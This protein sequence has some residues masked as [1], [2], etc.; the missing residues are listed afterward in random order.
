MKFQSRWR[1]YALRAR[2]SQRIVHKDLGGF[3]EVIPPLIAKFKGSGRIF[4]SELAQ[5]NFDWTDDER[6]FVEAKILNHKDFGGGIY[7][8]PGE[9]LTEEQKALVRNQSV[10]EEP[11]KRCVSLST[12]G[13]DV[14]QCPNE[15]EV[16]QDFCEEHRQE[17]K[18]T[19]GMTTAGVG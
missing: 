15:A 10:F 17:Q 4:D 3:V 14:V 12:E 5:R 6:K 19:K 18:I 2:K 11:R 7:L 13:F 1:N 8:A 16:G 9:E